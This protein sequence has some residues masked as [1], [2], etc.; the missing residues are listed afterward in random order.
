MK[1]LPLGILGSAT[2][3]AAA[4]AFVSFQTKEPKLTHKEMVLRGPAS[5]QHKVN[6]KVSG[7][8]QV[9]IRSLKS[10]VSGAGVFVS[11]A[12]ELL[13]EVVA[14]TGSSVQ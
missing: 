8:Y 10:P 7:N 9:E 4:L 11:H 12:V 1:K 2:V 6:A 5:H 14:T 3:A 13:R